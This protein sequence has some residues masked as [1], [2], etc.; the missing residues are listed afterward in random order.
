MYRFRIKWFTEEEGE[1]RLSR[2]L[3]NRP[4]EAQAAARKAARHNALHNAIPDE[5]HPTWDTEATVWMEERTFDGAWH[6]VWSV[7]ERAE[8]WEREELRVSP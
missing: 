4:E 5:D 2:Q 6:E 3:Y 8:H 7:T 1:L